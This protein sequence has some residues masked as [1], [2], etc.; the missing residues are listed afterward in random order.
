MWGPIVH[1]ASVKNNDLKH[2]P[3][4][5]LN[6]GGLV[7]PGPLPQSRELQRTASEGISLGQVL[8]EA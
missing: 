6:L 2:V 8:Q 5:I 4:H 7:P 3:L 1:D